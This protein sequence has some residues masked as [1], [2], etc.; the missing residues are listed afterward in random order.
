MTPA[1]LCALDPVTVSIHFN[2]KWQSIFSHLITSKEAPLFGEVADHFWQIEYQNRGAPHVHCV[3]WI[4]DAPVLGRNSPDEVKAYLNKV[5]TCAKPDPVTSPTLSQLVSQF[6]EHK[7]NNYCQKSYKHNGKF[8][9]KCRFGFPRPQKTHTDL[10]DPLECL[11]VLKAKQPR[12]RLY[13][14]QRKADEAQI[15]DYN[16]ALLLANQVNVDVQYIGHT[17]SRLPYYIT[18]YMTKHE[19]SEQDQMWQDTFTS[20]KALGTNAMSFMLK[21]VKSRQ[22]G[23]NEAADRL[24]GHK[25][26]SKSRQMR[27]C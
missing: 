22:V 5:I 21:S 3:L 19:R 20:S 2:K 4:K 10:N 16:P 12:K 17:G 25:L 7:C 8:F 27:F 11:A 9:K 24:L 23:A 26:Y 15:N 18:E 14:M 6:Q 1:E 13:N